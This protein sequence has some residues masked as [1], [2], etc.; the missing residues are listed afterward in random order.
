MN[1]LVDEGKGQFKDKDGKDTN[2]RGYVIDPATGDVINNYDGETM[3]KKA[4]LDERGEVPPPFNVEKHNFN[5]HKVRGDFEHDR[6][7][8]PVIS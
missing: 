2:Q 5:P 1:N 4:E 6:N 8:R 7:G 3:F